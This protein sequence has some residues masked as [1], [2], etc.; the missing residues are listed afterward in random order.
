MQCKS[1][2]ERARGR[3]LS[4]SGPSSQV[5]MSA[6]SSGLAWLIQRRGVTPLVLFWIRSS[7][8]RATKCGKIFVRSS[9]CAPDRKTNGED[10]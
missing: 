6:A 2:C 10:E 8:Y 1:T 9:S 7:P 5:E 3:A 4:H